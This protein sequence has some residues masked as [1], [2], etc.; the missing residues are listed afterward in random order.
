[1]EDLDTC[2]VDLLPSVES[3]ALAQSSYRVGER[4]MDV[5]EEHFVPTVLASMRERHD[6]V[7]ERMR[8]FWILLQEALP[9]MRMVEVRDEHPSNRVAATSKESDH[10]EEREPVMQHKVTKEE[11][12]QPLHNSLRGPRVALRSPGRLMVF[13]SGTLK[14]CQWYVNCA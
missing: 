5:M 9:W 1:M 6:I 3:S 12:A 4:M 10:K 11:Y 14:I 2:V 7:E 13:V 8:T